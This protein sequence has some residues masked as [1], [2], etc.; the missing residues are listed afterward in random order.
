[1]SVKNFKNHAA[2][3]GPVLA[4]FNLLQCLII[5][6]IKRIQFI[7]SA[8]HPG[9]EEPTAGLGHQGPGEESQNFAPKISAHKN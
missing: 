3:L 6:A 5:I 7:Y 9:E 1:M 2:D 4:L 8:E